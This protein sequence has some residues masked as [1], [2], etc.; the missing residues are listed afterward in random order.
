MDIQKIEHQLIY[1][2]PWPLAKEVKRIMKRGPLIKKI[3][4]AS[5][6]SRSRRTGDENK[7][8]IIDLMA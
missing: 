2:Y 7:G 8:K 5:E 1:F 6:Y 3:E 4:A